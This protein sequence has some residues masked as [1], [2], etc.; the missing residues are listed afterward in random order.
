MLITDQFPVGWK[1]FTTEKETPLETIWQ[2]KKNGDGQVVLIGKGKPFG[3][4]RTIET[5]EDFEFGFEWKYPTDANGNS[6]V[7]I[8]TVEEDKIWPKSIQVQLHG[9]TAGS[10]FPSAGAKTE[11]TLNVKDLSRPVNQ[12][13]TCTIRAENGKVSVVLNGKKAGEVTGCTPDKGSIALQSEGSEIHFR[14]VWVRKVK[15]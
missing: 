8:Y 6:G 5:F 10:V 11:N 2:T 7:L 12:W 4:L 1:H 9:P 15:T 14:N 13:N 3:Y